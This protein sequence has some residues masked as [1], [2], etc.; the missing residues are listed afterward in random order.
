MTAALRANPQPLAYAVKDA[1]AAVGISPAK[2]EELIRR[3]DLFVRWVDGKRV[4]TA[5]ELTAW[6]E[7]LPLERAS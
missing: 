4:I 5:T 7:S 3:D 2:L 6:L 1:A